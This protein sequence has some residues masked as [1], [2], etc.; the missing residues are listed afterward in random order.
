MHAY[1]EVF[2]CGRKIFLV[3]I[4]VFF[5]PNS[6]EQFMFG[7]LVCFI[8]YGAYAYWRPYEDENDDRL[9][10]AAQIEIFCALMSWVALESS[11]ESPAMAVALTG[12]LC[13]PPLLA[14]VYQTGLDGEVK[15]FRKSLQ[16][17][18][19][20]LRI[21]RRILMLVH[22]A[23]Q[24]PHFDDVEEVSK[25][26]DQLEGRRSRHS[27]LKFTTFTE[28]AED[29]ALPPAVDKKPD[30]VTTLSQHGS[31]PSLASQLSALGIKSEKSSRIPSEKGPSMPWTIDQRL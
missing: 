23:F 24:R 10:T 17:S 12:M 29:H 9:Q 20:F 18:E 27:G 4:P 22:A 14:L 30:E 21:Q 19:A 28:A 7:M 5:P 25:Q 2:E 13:V 15:K 31:V 1:F 16:N 3:G 11:S 6:V 8:S 26:R